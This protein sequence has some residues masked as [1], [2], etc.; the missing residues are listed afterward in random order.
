MVNKTMP[1]VGSSHQL[2]GSGRPSA[3]GGAAAVRSHHQCSGA[4]SGP[5]CNHAPSPLGVASSSPAV[6]PSLVN[7]CSKYRAMA[8]EFKFMEHLGQGELT[9]QLGLCHDLPSC[10]LEDNL[11]KKVIE[12]ANI[13]IWIAAK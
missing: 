12:K 2:P 7:W 6:N 3:A 11:L 10:F 13:K 1:S 8:L 4:R 9:A 5:R